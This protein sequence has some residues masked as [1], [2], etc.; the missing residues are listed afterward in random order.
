MKNQ[1]LNVQNAAVNLR[2]DWCSYE[3]AKYAVE[4]WHYSR[5]MPTS[6]LVKIG[7]WEEGVFI[8]TII[9]GVGAGNSTNGARF[10]LRRHYDMAELVRVALNSHMTPT[11]KLVSISIRMVSKHSP[12]LKLLTS[13]ADTAQGHV[14]TIYQAS[15]WLYFGGK[16]KGAYSVNGI[17]VHPRTLHNS[18][19][20]GGQSIPWLRANIDPA[21]RRIRTPV[22]HHYLYPLD[23]QT[24]LKI[25]PLAKPYPK[26]ATSETIDTPGD[27]PGE[28]GEAPTVA[29]QERNLCLQDDQENQPI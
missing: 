26:R 6:K 13:F 22:K 25:L 14:G 23:R 8:G 11:S 17:I 29:L 16:E 12:G 15:G 20:K 2:L 19:G 27:Q 18:Y 3:A 1:K 21:A 10:G 9:Y 24:R 5:R 7:V 4:H 28:G